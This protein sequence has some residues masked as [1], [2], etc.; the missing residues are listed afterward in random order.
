[1]IAKERITYAGI[2]QNRLPLIKR[3]IPKVIDYVDNIVIVDAFSTDGTKEWLENYSPKITVS[4]RVWDDSF[5]RQYSEF[6]KYIKDG[7]FLV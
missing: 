2:T 7:W 6:L 1:M 5:A 4:Q 3:N